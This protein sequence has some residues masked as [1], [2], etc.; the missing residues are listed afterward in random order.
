MRQP[1]GV[2]IFGIS[3]LLY[4]GYWLAILLMATPIW[5]GMLSEDVLKAGGVGPFVEKVGWFRVGL[6]ILFRLFS[7]PIGVVGSIGA[8]MRWNWGRWL[9]IILAC[10][11]ILDAIVRVM[12]WVTYGPYKFETGGTLA[13]MTWCSLIIWYFLRPAVKAQFVRKKA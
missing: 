10:G 9:L 6:E 2:K 7:V 5:F 3:S 13:L 12:H 1:L 4:H 11:Y 8:L